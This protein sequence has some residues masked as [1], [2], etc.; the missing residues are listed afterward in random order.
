[1]ADFSRW[2][3]GLYGLQICASMA[4]GSLSRDMALLGIRSPG[5]MWPW[6]Q[7][8]MCGVPAVH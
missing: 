5:L 4:G 6:Y 7:A 3:S 1:M 2:E 8:E